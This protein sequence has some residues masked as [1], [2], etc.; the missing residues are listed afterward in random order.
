M[1]YCWIYMKWV[2]RKHEAHFLWK[3][4][5]WCSTV[6]AGTAFQTIWES[7]KSRYEVWLVFFFLSF[8]SLA[9]VCGT[10]F[11]P[12]DVLGFQLKSWKLCNEIWVQ[13]TP[14]HFITRSKFLRCDCISCIVFWNQIWVSLNG[15]HLSPCWP[16]CDG[17]HHEIVF[18]LALPVGRI[19]WWWKFEKFCRMMW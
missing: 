8:S 14:T 16:T 18:D 1:S 3:L 7:W 2:C 10:S 19:S 9:I 5:V 6:W 13:V 12:I 4:W 11:S 17:S 15:L